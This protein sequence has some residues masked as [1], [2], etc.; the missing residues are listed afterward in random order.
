[1]ITTLVNALVLS[2]VRYCL[3]VYGNGTKD[4]F[5]RLQ[6]I[7]NYA[8]KVIFGRKKFDPAS[9]LLKK[10]GWLAAEDLAKFHTLA[11]THKVL[12]FGEPDEL[13]EQFRTVGETHSR[14][15]RQD[16]NLFV[17]FSST[18]MGRRRFCARAPDMY[19]SLPPE[20][21]ELPVQSFSRTLKRSLL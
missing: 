20:M 7:I 13:A 17:P 2:Q 1:V 19:N 12:R 8:A 9:D 15:T 10:L 3:S 11:L 18:N 16:D 6:K 21:R 14:S 5:S 4:N